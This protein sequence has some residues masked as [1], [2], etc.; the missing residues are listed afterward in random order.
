MEWRGKP[1]SCWT[2]TLHMSIQLR[3]VQKSNGAVR[4]HVLLLILL[5]HWHVGSITSSWLQWLSTYITNP[6]ILCLVMVHHMLVVC[7]PI[8]E[9][10]LTW[11]ANEFPSF[12][13]MIQFVML[14]LKYGLYNNSKNKHIIKLKKGQSYKWWSY[15]HL[16]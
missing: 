2:V 5:I 6:F 4:T 7:Q 8:L 9:P 15:L 10:M 11:P 14:N 16:I 3:F 12:F 13:M 1:T